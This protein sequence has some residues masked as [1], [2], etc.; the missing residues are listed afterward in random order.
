M[1]YIFG[2]LGCFA[3]A[4]LVGCAPAG[5]PEGYARADETLAKYEVDE[6]TRAEFEKYA[7]FR[8]PKVLAFSKSG[9]MGDIWVQGPGVTAKRMRAEMGD[10]EYDKMMDTLSQSALAECR[11]GHIAP[12]PR[13]RVMMI[14]DRFVWGE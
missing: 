14:D 11:D 10:V 2:V 8:G 4:L 12:K 6:A 7:R 9:A 13:C 3:L 1:R 5:D